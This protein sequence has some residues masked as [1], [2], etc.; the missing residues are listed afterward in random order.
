MGRITEMIDP[1]NIP[2][3]QVV[4]VYTACTNSNVGFSV[5]VTQGDCQLR[6]SGEQYLFDRV[7]W[8]SL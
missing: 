5:L 4:S 1:G 7:Q 8:E 2:G 3:L 6:C